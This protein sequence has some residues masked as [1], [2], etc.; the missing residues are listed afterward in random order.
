[1]NMQ[2]NMDKK[3]YVWID[4]W[5]YIFSISV[6]AIHTQPLIGYE[7]TTI[8]R[9]YYVFINC[10][11]PFFFLASGFL[12]GIYLIVP[13]YV[14]DNIQ[15]LKKRIIKNFKLYIIWSLIYLPF[16]IWYYTSGKF[17]LLYS[18]VHYMRGFVL[19]GQHYNSQILWYL[20]S[21]VYSLLLIM[22]MVK[23]KVS[24][25]G[26]LGI[27]TILYLVSL[28]TDYLTTEDNFHSGILKNLS[29]I[30]RDTIGNGRI[31]SGCFFV[32]IG[33]VIAHIHVNSKV[34]VVVMIGGARS[35]YFKW[36]NTKTVF[37]YIFNSF[38]HHY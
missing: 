36:N 4:I 6:V 19:M 15:I 26:I 14:E 2:G 12:T 7:N 17:S 8:Y 25:K 5:K 16:D 35:N 10:A 33:I 31:L 1:M 3:R 22:I 13:L 32:C 28:I 30:I 24:I 37:E 23:R 21:L 18:L 11:V 34:V 27:S 20:L 29:I 38:F 9:P